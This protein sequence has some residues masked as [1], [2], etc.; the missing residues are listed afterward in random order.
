MQ[1]ITGQI[2][3]QWRRAA[4]PESSLFTVCSIT[5][6]T[7]TKTIFTSVVNQAGSKLS[8]AI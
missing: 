1:G 8:V 2:D 5:D 4:K 6:R 3:F 7:D